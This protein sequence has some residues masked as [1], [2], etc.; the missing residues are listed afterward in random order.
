M[1]LPLKL[2]GGLI[3]LYTLVAALRVVVFYVLQPA[4]LRYPTN[5]E[6]LPIHLLPLPVR[7][8]VALGVSFMGLSIG[9]M[10]IM[11][12]VEVFSFAQMAEVALIMLHLAVTK[13]HS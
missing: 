1:L 6:R 7:L 11:P 12:L 10:M 4:I 9:V 5:E 2:L 3:S 13:Y 8:W